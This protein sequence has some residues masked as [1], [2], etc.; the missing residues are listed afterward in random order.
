[1]AT[2]PFTTNALTGVSAVGLGTSVSRPGVALNPGLSAAAL[3]PALTALREPV[4]VVVRDN[5]PFLQAYDT[6]KVV[7]VYRPRRTLVVGQ[8]PRAGEL[9]PVGTPIDLTVTVKEGLPLD[10]FKELD[11]RIAERFRNKNIGDV[12][13]TLDAN[14]DAK[15]V[16]EREGATDYDQLSANEKGVVNEYMRA[17]LGVDPADAAGAKRAYGDMKSMVDF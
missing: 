13:T 14:E 6:K 11:P 8:S 12:L 4:Q 5:K 10:G 3:N 9:V 17:N 2:R 1:M 7:E 15:R 16:F